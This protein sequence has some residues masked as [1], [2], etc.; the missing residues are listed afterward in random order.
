MIE[1]AE[2]NS[3]SQNCNLQQV[4]TCRSTCHLQKWKIIYSHCVV[5]YCQ[6]YL[7]PR[8]PLYTMFV[9]AKWIKPTALMMSGGD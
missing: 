7:G 6:L 3:K 4:K 5:Y 9:S 2:K 1:V 8:E